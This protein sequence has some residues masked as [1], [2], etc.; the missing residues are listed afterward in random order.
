MADRQINQSEKRAALER[1]LWRWGMIAALVVGCFC[2]Y[3]FDPRNHEEEAQRQQTV[4]AMSKAQAFLNSDDK[5]AAEA[6]MLARELPFETVADKDA[7]FKLL[8]YAAENG[9]DSVLIRY[10]ECLDP[11]LPPWGNTRKNG[12]MA[13]NIYKS[14]PDQ[15]QAARVMTHLR[16]WLEDRSQAGDALAAQW[17]KEIEGRAN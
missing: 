16:G 13:W 2:W 12:L 6:A 1:K 9:D 11:S 17:L 4:T 15:E 10:G 14:S 7:I 8:A 3:W 5:T